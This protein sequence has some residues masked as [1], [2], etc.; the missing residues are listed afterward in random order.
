M[1][2]AARIPCPA[3]GGL[4]HPISGR[5]KHCKADLHA[6]R[7]SRPAAAA[8]LPALVGKGPPAPP[9]EILP[10][11]ATGWRMRAAPPERRGV[12]AIAIAA[13]AVGAG[14]IIVVV[15]ALTRPRSHA[16]DR[17]IEPL[18]ERAPQA[19]LGLTKPV[20]PPPAVPPPAVPPVPVDA[21]VVNA[22]TTVRPP[23]DGDLADYTRDLQP[24]DALTATIKTTLGTIRCELFDDRAPKTVA[25]FIGLAT[26]KKAWL[27]PRSGGTRVGVPFYDGLTFHRVIEEFMIQGGD[28]LGIGSGGPGYT[29]EDEIDPALAMQV[30]SLAMANA[31]PATNGSQF[32]ITEIAP[33]WLNG[34][35][36]I[37]GRCGSTA[38]VKR[39]ARVRTDD[40]SKPRRPI[41]IESIEIA[42]E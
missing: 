24:G 41:T 20:V 3:C 30:G 1:A 12:P 9:A 32:F 27:D 34:K 35:H 17:V 2:D 16:A 10:P 6:L 22:A 15:V 25:N 31:G 28:P 39:I 21:A 38:V 42:R 14:A 37:F 8:Q 29:F 26:G 19:E 40:L 11:R 36:T 5:C 13:I 4:V 33:S 18:A 7:G 23:A